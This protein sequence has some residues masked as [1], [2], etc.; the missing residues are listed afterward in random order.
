MYTSDV[1][2]NALFNSV[3]REGG[4]VP[5]DTSL[6]DL[7][8]DLSTS[9]G[10]FQT[11]RWLIKNQGGTRGGDGEGSAEGSQSDSKE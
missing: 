10:S 2:V 6:P 11:A 3:E 1:S 5:P 4:G 7:F 9:S 8:S